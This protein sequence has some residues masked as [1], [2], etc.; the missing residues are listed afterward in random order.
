MCQYVDVFYKT[1][2]ITFTLHVYDFIIISGDGGDG[3]GGT[4]KRDAKPAAAAWVLLLNICRREPTGNFMESVGQ[5]SALF[6]VTKK[7]GLKMSFPLTNQ[8][9]F[10]PKPYQSRS[11]AFT[12]YKIENWTERIIK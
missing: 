6:V 8:L 5:L 10:V 3:G 12:L 9:Y 1:H 7:K 2:Y 11:T 4:G